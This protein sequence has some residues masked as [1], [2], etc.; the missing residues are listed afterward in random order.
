MGTCRYCGQNASF[1]RKQHG[2]CRDLHTTSTQEMTQL[3]AQAAGFNEAALRNTL[4][5]IAN[6]ARA[7]EDE[8]SQA[9]AAGWTQ[10]VQNA[11]SDGILTREEEI[12]LRDFRDR[13]AN[14][15]MPS[16]ITA[17]ATLDRA[18][19]DQI[20]SQAQNAALKTGDGGAALQE[21]DHTLRRASMSD[22]NRRALLVRV[23]EVAVEGPWRTACCPWT[24]RTRW[25]STPP[26]SVWSS[27]TWTGTA[28]RPAWCRRR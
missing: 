10:G 6:R 16:V 1:L 22:T 26:T 25:P 24:R 23:W 4:R 2:P 12:L 18:S 11:M 27:M 9:I 5:A 13:M 15:D 28:S 3:A 21:L 14:Q 19:A 17:S 20:A 8:I 7:T